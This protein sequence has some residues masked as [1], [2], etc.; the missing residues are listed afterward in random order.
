MADPPRVP[1]RRVVE[2]R[3]VLHLR[4]V[5]EE[6]RFEQLV[7]EEPLEIRVNGEP[8]AVTMRTPGDDFDLAVG[9]CLTEGIVDS[10]RE[11]ATVRYCAGRDPETG[12]QTY[13]VV[14]VALR[15]GGPV[16]EDLRRNVYMASSCGICGTASLEAVRKRTPPVD[17]DD[18]RVGVD[19]LRSLPDRL[20][21]AQRVF[22]R[23]GGLH[24]AGV[25]DATGG[26][27]CVREDVGRHNA[28]DKAIGWAATA[29]ALP[30]T[31]HL[32]MVSGRLAFEIV[33]K[34]Q[35]AS[36]PVVAAVSAP[37]SLAVALADGAGMTLV[38]FLRGDTMNV[39]TG[40]HRI[41]R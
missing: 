40:E 41:I 33:Q 32:L 16:A 39:Y 22:D 21:A 23:T 7:T 15:R 14:D 29:A 5:Q 4:G 13:N 17:A 36:L 31:G 10:P 3:A 25:F 38:G 34:A 27:R 37:S 19:V 8:V 28:V 2:K 20:R 26:L 24:A 6:R 11:V 30:L 9:F 35:R 1:A 18:V 12:V